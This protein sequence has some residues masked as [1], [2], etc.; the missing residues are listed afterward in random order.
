MTL[1]QFAAESGV[2]I[3][4]LL[5]GKRGGCSNFQLLGVC[6]EGCSYAHEA[7]VI[8]EGKQRDLSSALLRGMKAIEDKKKVTTP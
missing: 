1:T 4:E 8:P 7:I 2:P 5:S 6:K 3:R